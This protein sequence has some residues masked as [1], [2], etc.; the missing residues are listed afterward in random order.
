MPQAIFT[1]DY[2]FTLES[3]Q[4]LPKLVIAYHTYGT[5]N[6]QADNVIWVCHALTASSDVADWWPHTVETDR[7]LDPD[8]HFIICANIL[9]S[10][11]GTTGPLHLNPA[12][13]LPYYGDFPDITIRDMAAAHQL[14]AKHLGINR[15]VALIGSS[16]GGFQAL[17]WAVSEPDFIEKL[18]LI[19]TAP[20]ASPWAIAFD[21]TQRMAIRADKSFGQPRPDAASEGLAAAR[22]I[23]LLSYRGESGYNITQQDPDDALKPADSHRASTYQLH[24]GQKLKNRFNAYSYVSILNSFDSHDVGRNRGG[25]AE[26]LKRITAKTLTVGI[27]TDLLFTPTD[28][29][30]LDAMIGDSRY[31]EIDSPFGHDGFLVEHQQL[32]DILYPFINEN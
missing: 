11:Y 24:Q 5:L 29:K 12:T 26:A 1:Y 2:P 6:A 32:N 21:Q 9:G 14:L 3:G 22:A 13:G 28:M 18:V 23:A 10:H 15:I 20:K 27:S 31:Y 4:I 8:R 30:K 17:E 16:L 19:A 25:V 7:F